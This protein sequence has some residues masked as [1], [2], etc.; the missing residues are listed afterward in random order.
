MSTLSVAFFCLSS[1]TATLIVRV[2]KHLQERNYWSFL[3]FFIHLFWLDVTRE[4]EKWSQ[5]NPAVPIMV[6]TPAEVH[7]RWLV[8][9]RQSSLFNVAS[10]FFERSFLLYS[11]GIVHQDNRHLSLL[12]TKLFAAAK[13][14]YLS[15][16]TDGKWILRPR[17]ELVLFRMHELYKYK[18][19]QN[20]LK[21]TLNPINKGRKVPFNV[22]TSCLTFSGKCL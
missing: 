8:A 1:S 18:Q 16:N 5:L 10:C 2:G 15:E 3:I 17:L 14:F 11:H 19:C 12:F 9:A 20:M 6:T 21:C 13:S 4:K 22:D 7:I